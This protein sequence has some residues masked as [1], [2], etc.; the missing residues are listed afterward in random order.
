M[1]TDLNTQILKTV[2]N[3]GLTIISEV[4]PSVRSISLGVWVKTG[5]R[6]ENAQNNGIAHFLE[7]MVFNHAKRESR[8]GK[9]QLRPNG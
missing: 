8:G 6:Y 7:H 1:H 2:L 4:I 3:N 5:T 9:V